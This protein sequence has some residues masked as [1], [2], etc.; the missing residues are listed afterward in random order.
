MVALSNDDHAE[1][2]YPGDYAEL[3]E[4]DHGFAAGAKWDGEESNERQEDGGRQCESESG[5]HRTVLSVAPEYSTHE[6]E[7]SRGDGHTDNA[8]ER[9]SENDTSLE[10]PQQ[11]LIIFYGLAP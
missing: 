10:Q 3:N 4:S 6:P 2:D 8:A 7:D 11:F 9:R 1:D 5:E